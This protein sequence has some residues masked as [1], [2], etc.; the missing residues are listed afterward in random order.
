[1]TTTHH[2]R[3]IHARA[4]AE[5]VQTWLWAGN[6]GLHCGESLPVGKVPT[7]H[8]WGWGSGV[9]VH[10]REDA[11]APTRGILL[12]AEAAA[13]TQPVATEEYTATDDGPKPPPHPVD[14]PG[15]FLRCASRQ[16]ESRFSALQLRVVVVISPT[17]AVLVGHDPNRPARLTP[18][19]S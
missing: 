2:A 8:L 13:D 17:H 11:C 16:D 1:M 19:P 18:E 10:L 6:D 9:M 7:G 3:A 14:E 12:T 5:G 15:R 4:E